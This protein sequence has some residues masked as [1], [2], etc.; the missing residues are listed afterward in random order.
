M[1]MQAMVAPIATAIT[2]CFATAVAAPALP[3]L[4][5]NQFA[6]TNI[7]PSAA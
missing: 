4:G 6:Q 2:Q 7:L 5:E 1:T 3:V